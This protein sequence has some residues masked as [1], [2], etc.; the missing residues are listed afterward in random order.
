MLIWLTDQANTVNEKNYIKKNQSILNIK[1]NQSF[2]AALHPSNP[3]SNIFLFMLQGASCLSS[4]R[5]NMLCWPWREACWCAA[6]RIPPLIRWS[7]CRATASQS[8]RDEKFLTCPGCPQGAD[9]TAALP[10]SSHR[11]N[12]SCFLVTALKTAG[13]SQPSTSSWCVHLIYILI[14]SLIRLWSFAV[15]GWIWSGKWERWVLTLALL[16]I[17]VLVS[18]SHHKM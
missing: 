1:I 16:L 17:K 3:K 14:E 2:L 10:W 12:F 9:E 13:R 6:M 4:G 15:C 5:R 11:T 8:R 7:L 18:I